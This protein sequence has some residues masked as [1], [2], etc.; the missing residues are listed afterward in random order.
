MQDH[1][2]KALARLRRRARSTSPRR[3]APTPA[4]TRPRQVVHFDTRRRAR[5]RRPGCAA[6]TA[7]CIRQRAC[8]GAAPCPTTST[9]ATAPARAP[10]ATCCSNRAGA[11]GAA[12]RAR[13]AGATGRWTSEAM[14]GAA[15]LLLGEHDFSAFRAA[16]CQAKSPVRTICT[17]RAS[18]AAADL[19]CSLRGQRLPAPHGAQPHGLPGLRGRGPAAAAWIAEV[20]AG[21][22]PARRRADLRARRALLRRP[23][24]TMPVCGM[25]GLP[26]ALPACST[27]IAMNRERTRIKICGLRDAGARTAR[28]ATRAPM[29]SASSS[30]R[31][32]PRARRRPRGRELAAAAAAVRRRR[33]G[34]S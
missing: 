9:R 27:R 24:T 20:L 14:R 13:W 19:A 2:E 10:T 5:P 22:R 25:P 31:A 32:S 15:R 4:C 26:A 7:S 8:C 28:G 6:P 33:W 23:S 34:C 1:L 21:A 30:M 17:R 3:G 11:P 18:S 16:E 29:R 12:A